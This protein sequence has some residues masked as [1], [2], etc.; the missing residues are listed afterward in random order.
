MAGEGHT[1]LF[2]GSPLALSGTGIKVGDPLREVKLTQTD[3][4]LVNI[5]DTKG[6][7]RSGSS[8]SCRRSTP[9]CAN[10]RPII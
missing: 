6:K 3:L 10:N 8:A 2:K 4:S 7:G 5:T 9:K 1:V